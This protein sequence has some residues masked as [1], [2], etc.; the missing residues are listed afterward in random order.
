MGRKRQPGKQMAAQGQPQGQQGGQVHELLRPRRPVGTARSS[1][2]FDGFPRFYETSHTT[3]FRDRLNLRYDAIFA[4]NRAIFEGARV[5]DIASHDG[6]WSLAALETGAKSVV[7]IEGKADLV[8]HANANLAAYVE[9]DSRY[10]F[11]AGDVLDVLAR[12][13]IDVDVVMCLGFLYHTL[14]YN[15]LM[16]RI[17]Q[18]NPRK[19]IIDTQ[20]HPRAKGP[21]VRMVLDKAG[22]QRDAIADDYSYGGLVLVGHPSVPAVRMMAKA[23]GYE[24]ESFS[25][26]GSLLRDNPTAS[27]VGDYGDLSRVTLVLTPAEEGAGAA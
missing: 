2:F 20:V 9:D 12:E 7:G 19:V 18:L 26:W 14:R 22:M 1:H 15:E 16:W 25:D 13:K 27:D 8:E 3:A 6:R 17:R 11:Y 23:Y 10:T 24:V 5:L 21:F 4:E